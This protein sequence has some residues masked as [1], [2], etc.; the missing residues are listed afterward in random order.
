MA[1]E[2]PEWQ[3]V[4]VE[5]RHAVVQLRL[6]TDGRCLVW[7]AVAHREIMEA[8]EWVATNRDFK[9][10]IL[11]GSGDEFCTE[12]DV[13]SFAGIEWDYIWWEGRRILRAI[14][15]LEIP[16]ISAVNGPA[17]VHS[18]LMVMGDIVLAATTAEFADHAHFAVRDTVP[19]D[20]INLVWSEILGPIRSKYWLLTGAVIRADE[21]LSLGVVN[22]VC[23]PNLLIDRAWALAQDLARRD[24]AVLRYTKAAISIGTRRNFNEGLSHGLGVEGSGHWSRGGIRPGKFGSGS[25]ESNER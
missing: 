7:D 23:E 12:I 22:E 10:A 11:T 2:R 6:H 14:N 5:I 13:S 24:A 20:G 1:T 25:H 16:L 15:D 18:E 3:R 17:T 9:V 21:A 8:F 4:A 19:G